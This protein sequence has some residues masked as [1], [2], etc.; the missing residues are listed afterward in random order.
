MYNLINKTTGEIINENINENINLSIKE[1]QTLNYAY[2]CNKSDLI[3]VDVY[4]DVEL[5]LFQF[6]QPI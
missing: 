4:E 2:I 1:M 5:N 3:Y 6:V